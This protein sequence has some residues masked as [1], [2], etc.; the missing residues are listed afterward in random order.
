MVTALF[1]ATTIF[2]PRAQFH[3]GLERDDYL[4]RWFDRPLYQD[5]SYAAANESGR[6]LNPKSWATTVKTL[7]LGKCVGIG[8][9]IDQGGRAEV[10]PMSEAAG[11]TFLAEYDSAHS[12][13]DQV[14][15]I[16]RTAELAI[17]SPNAFRIDGRVVMSEYGAKLY[18]DGEQLEKELDVYVRARQALA[19]KFGPDKFYVMPYA[20]L[21]PKFSD[22][23]QPITEEMK[24]K[25]EERIRTYLRK[26]DGFVWDGR[27]AVYARRYDGRKR[28]EI[29]TPIVRKVFDEPEFKGKKLGVLMRPGHENTYLIGYSLDSVGTQTLRTCLES[30]GRMKADFAVGAEWDEENENTFFEPTVANAHSTQRILAYYADRWAGREPTVF[31]GD[32]TTIPN[33]IISYRKSLIAGEPLE[34]EVANVPDGTFAGETFEIAVEWRAADGTS[35]ERFSPQKLSADVCDAVWFRVPVSKLVGEHRALMPVVGVRWGKQGKLFRDG[36]WPVDLNPTRTVEFKWVKQPVRDLAKGVKAALACDRQADGSYRFKGRVEGGCPFRS[37]EVLDGVDT[38]RMAGDDVPA[39]DRIT[40]RFGIQGHIV[41]RGK[42]PLTGEIRFLNAGDVKVSEP[43]PR[44]GDWIRPD[45]NGYKFNRYDACHVDHV[46][47]A[48]FPRTAIET[49]EI[50]YELLPSFAKK[51]IKVSELV[52]NQVY[53]DA[54]EGGIALTFQI[55]DRVRFQPAPFGKSVA[56]FDFVFTPGDRNPVIRVQAV[57]ENYRVWRSRPFVLNEATGEMR[58]IHVYERDEDR[59]SEVTI[60]A[61]RLDDVCYDFSDTSRGTVVWTGCRDLSLQLGGS[62]AQVCGFGNGARL[63]GNLI[64]RQLTA[65]TPEWWK[66][67]PVRTAEGGVELKGCAFGCIPWSVLPPYSGFELSVKVKPAAIGKPMTVLGASHANFALQVNAQGEAEAIFQL[68]NLIDRGMTMNRNVR[69]PMLKVGEWNDVRVVFDQRQATVFVN[70]KSGVSVPVTGYEYY[71]GTFVLGG[72]E[73]NP[74]FFQ[75]E[76]KDLSILG[77]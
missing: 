11:T 28:D 31:P 9:F 3:Y 44:A 14:A 26:L 8:T 2:F 4:H 34:L 16:V 58:M 45:G 38:M 39:A 76:L 13:E 17:K 48:D 15:H 61:S 42:Y 67:V 6:F 72:N 7:K 68:G 71:V 1:L 51:R 5:T 12:G 35:V 69:G 47:F 46:L 37:V 50:E 57:D 30:A 56:D 10:I 33:L 59:V 29:W 54:G 60:P 18:G 55:Y 40:V 20:P 63:Y 49:A 74:A 22:I 41:T 70:G 77:R 25:A 75:G 62:V 24:R 27:E 65:K 43:Y 52:K 36:L 64:T 66:S 73:R 53:G 23:G 21:V 19:E 32:D